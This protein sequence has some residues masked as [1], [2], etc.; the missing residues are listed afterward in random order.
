MT[1]R[2][3]IL[4]AGGVFDFETRTNIPPSLSDSGWQAYQAWLTAGNTPLP[5]D[6]VG[7]ATDLATA[8]AQRKS[9]IDAYAAGLRNQVVRGYSAG[10]MASWSFKLAEARAFTATNDP[11]QAPT[12]AASATIRGITVAAMAAKVLANSAP[13]LNAEAAIDGI[14]GKHS[15]AIDAC[16]DIPSIITYNWHVGWP[17]I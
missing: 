14:R 2:Y 1:S 11:L 3:Q 8:K 12:L 13:F 9:E 7:Q 16:P 6:P 4:Q 5:P 10:E 15:D 17:V